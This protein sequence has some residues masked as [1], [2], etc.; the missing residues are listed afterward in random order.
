MVGEKSLFFDAGPIITLVM[1]RLHWILPKLKEKF[2]GKFYITPAVKY[3]LVD[4]PL[5]VK[6]YKLEA[7]QVNKMICEGLLEVY[8][9]V[10]KSRATKLIN[11]ANSSFKLNGKNMDIMQAG[12]VESVVCALQENAA[13][14]VMDERTLRLLIENNRKMKRLLESRFKK[15]VEVNNGKMDEFSSQF[16][17][18]KIIRSIE[19]A[20]VAYKMGLLDSYGKCIKNKQSNIVDAVLWATKFNGC[21]VTE[22]EIDEIGRILLEKL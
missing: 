3:E 14:V 22:H 4:R 6:R 21:A 13:G 12:E 5:N 9:N 7:L 15:K 18:L 8:T 17:G 11:L 2:G 1:S 19:L 16:K 10:P 20:S